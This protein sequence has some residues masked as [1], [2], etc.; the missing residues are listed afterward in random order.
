MFGAY[1]WWSIVGL[2]LDLRPKGIYCFIVVN[3][4]SLSLCGR[5]SRLMSW[6]GLPERFFYNILKGCSPLLQ[7]PTANSK[8][9][10]ET[11]PYYIENCD[12]G[13]CIHSVR[14]PTVPCSYPSD[15][16]WDKSQTDMISQ[17]PLTIPGPHAAPLYAPAAYEA[18]KHTAGPSLNNNRIDPIAATSSSIT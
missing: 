17:N 6:D 9:P 16:G 13:F 5:Y 3:G 18:T 2:Q 12:E 10:P 8:I 7:Q 11:F 4:C 14:C 1:V 15:S